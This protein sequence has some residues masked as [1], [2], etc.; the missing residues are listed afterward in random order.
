[1]SADP[2]YDDHKRYDISSSMG[3]QLVCPVQR[4][5]ILLLP[6]YNWLNFMNLMFGRLSI[7]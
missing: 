4:Y 5:E 2:G 3:F 7:R 1:M 6:G